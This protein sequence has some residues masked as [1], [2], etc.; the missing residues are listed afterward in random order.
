MLATA[1]RYKK[2]HF[3]MHETYLVDLFQSTLIFMYIKHFR[4]ESLHKD[5]FEF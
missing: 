1:L 3:S 4:S 5:S 2:V